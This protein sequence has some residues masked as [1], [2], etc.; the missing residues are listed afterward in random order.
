MDLKI[1][2]VESILSAVSPAIEMP[3]LLKGQTGR[4]MEPLYKDELL[5]YGFGFQFENELPRELFEQL[6]NDIDQVRTAMFALCNRYGVLAGPLFSPLNIGMVFNRAQDE[7]IWHVDRS[8]QEDEYYTLLSPASSTIVKTWVSPVLHFL[9]IADAELRDSSH[10]ETC[11]A[12]R[13]N[14]KT[15]GSVTNSITEI[16]DAINLILNTFLP[17]RSQVLS[18]KLKEKSVLVG[19]KNGWLL[20]SDPLVIHN[21]D[22]PTKDDRHILTFDLARKDENEFYSVYDT[23]AES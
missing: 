4:I 15:T 22:L 17:E 23:K 8:D 2:T 19:G 12:V 13:K 11:E 20:F 18:A 14:Q 9:L 1:Q 16:A 3:K 21:G 7:T 10:S 6:R 5:P